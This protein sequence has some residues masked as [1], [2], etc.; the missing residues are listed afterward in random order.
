MERA[1]RFGDP[2][3][4]PQAGSMMRW[5]ITAAFLVNAALVGYG[6]AQTPAA[7]RDDGGL[8]AVAAL[9]ILWVTVLIGVWTGPL[10][11]TRVQPAILK[12]GIAA[13]VGLGLLLGAENLT[14]YLA[15]VTQDRSVVLGYTIIAAMVATFAI[16]GVLGARRG[17]TLRAGITAALWAVV[18]EYVLWYAALLSSYYAFA[19]GSRLEHVLQAEGTYAD[20]AR[21]GMTDMKAFIMQDYLGAGFF[22]LLIG[23]VMASL[24]GG[25]G[26]GLT[27]LLQRQMVAKR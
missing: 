18:A 13:G 10:S 27:R 19:S 6:L 3:A 21:S 12:I 15:P 23:F 16:A 17:G 20:F 22:H 14:E 4:V 8:I 2:A 11:A 24:F 1:E 25:I 9:A 7:A 5:A 26:A